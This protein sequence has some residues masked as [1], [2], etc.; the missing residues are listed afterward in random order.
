MF[1]SDGKKQLKNKHN[2]MNGLKG[3]LGSG[4][5]FTELKLSE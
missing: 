4:S 1:E 3:V 2:N 5:V